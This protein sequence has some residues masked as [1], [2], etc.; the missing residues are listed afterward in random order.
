MVSVILDNFAEG[1]TFEEIVQE[2]SPLSLEDIKSA[3]T[4]FGA[5]E[6]V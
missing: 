5:E 1:L 2:Y 6:I 4:Y 3:I